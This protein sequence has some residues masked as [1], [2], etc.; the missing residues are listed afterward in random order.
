MSLLKLQLLFSK[1][2]QLKNDLYGLSSLINSLD[3]LDCKIYSLFYMSRFLQFFL[4][5]IAYCI[6]CVPVIWLCEELIPRI[7]SISEKW[8]HHLILLANVEGSVG[9]S[10][11]LRIFTEM[12]NLMKNLSGTVSLL[13]II[14]LI[15][16]YGEFFALKKLK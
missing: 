6:L 3:L 5:I 9:R 4:A 11:N 7:E 10:Y 15:T 2:I 1:H 12:T 16:N 13:G 14:T 8:I